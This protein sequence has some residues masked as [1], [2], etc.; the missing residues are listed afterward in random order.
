MKKRIKTYGK[1]GI[2]EIIGNPQETILYLRNRPI[3]YSW[4]VE[5]GSTLR[6]TIAQGLNKQ[7]VRLNEKT[8]KS[9]KEGIHNTQRF[10]E[11]IEYFTPFFK[12][13]I[14]EYGYYE[15]IIEKLDLPSGKSSFPLS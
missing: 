13:G 9:L 6:Y 2:L 3:Q 12:Y 4:Y 8:Q 5:A 14:Y 15:L 10:L 1:K 11:I 7:A